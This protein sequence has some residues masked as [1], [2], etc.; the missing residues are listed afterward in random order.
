M[1]LIIHCYGLNACSA[2]SSVLG[3]RNSKRR[4][5]RK[6]Q[7]VKNENVLDIWL[8]KPCI[9]FRGCCVLVLSDSWM[10]KLSWY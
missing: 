2:P 9:D 8:I 7:S 1:V 10:Q 4:R 3:A 5:G 6:R